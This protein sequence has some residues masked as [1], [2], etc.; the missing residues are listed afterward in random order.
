[1]SET[2]NYT[3]YICP[4]SD[5]ETPATEYRTP[6]NISSST[7]DDV[8]TTTVHLVPSDDTYRTT[9]IVEFEICPD[10][11]VCASGGC[12][13][14]TRLSWVVE[15]WLTYKPQLTWVIPNYCNIRRVDLRYYRNEDDWWFLAGDALDETLS[16]IEIY[17]DGDSNNPDCP[18]CGLGDMEKFYLHSDPVPGT[19]YSLSACI[20]NDSC[21]NIDCSGFGSSNTELGAS[22]FETD[23]LTGGEVTNVAD[24]GDYK[25]FTIRKFV[26]S[27][28]NVIEETVSIN[29]V[30]LF[31]P[32][33]GDW[34]LLLK[35][36]C[37]GNRDFGADPNLAYNNYCVSSNFKVIPFDPSNP[38]PANPFPV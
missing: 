28:N 31:E 33:V 34:V 21:V 32:S 7:S 3:I 19:K 4:S 26:K 14:S 12:D 24:N 6:S 9:D 18:A 17:P 2:L 11:G 29:G 22:V 36:D 23:S 27:G 25:T 37:D 20:E 15:S 8:Q 30:D 16:P 13:Y 5:S 35:L 38:F 10:G 1:M